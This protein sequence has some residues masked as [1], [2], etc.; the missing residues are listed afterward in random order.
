MACSPD[1]RYLYTCDFS[2]KLKLFSTDYTCN[3][4]DFGHQDSKNSVMTMCFSKNGNY[5]YTGTSNGVIIQN[6]VKDPTLDKFYEDI[7]TE[8]SATSSP[9][10]TI[11]YSP[12]SEFMFV[13]TEAGELRQYSTSDYK[14]F[15]DYGVVMKG[16]IHSISMTSIPN[17]MLFVSDNTGRLKQYVLLQ[18]KS[19]SKIEEKQV[20]F[21]TLLGIHRSS[22]IANPNLLSRKLS[23]V[24]GNISQ[25]QTMIKENF[26]RNSLAPQANLLVLKKDYGQ[27]HDGAI[28]SIKASLLSNNLF[29]SS[30]NGEL[31]QFGVFE[32]KLIR[33]YGVIHKD[34]ILEIEVTLDEDFVFTS[35]HTGHLKQFHVREENIAKDYGRV[36]S[37]CIFSMSS[38]PDSCYLFTSDSKGH[39][40][41]FSIRNK[42]CIFNFHKIHTE[43]INCIT[44]TQDS[45]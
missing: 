8:A 26:S 34:N 3:L 37:G 30:V 22:N 19:E 18:D 39:I 7:I 28:M 4:K 32:E 35:D 2:G 29:T 10:N 11:V 14:L 23:S 12:D 40:K 20:G 24:A 45:K 13:G 15:K 17:P 5:L 27:V 16:S 6:C 43:A 21:L 33:S 44:T 31:N 38:T 42:M 25:N 1:S 36:H 9:V 41:Q